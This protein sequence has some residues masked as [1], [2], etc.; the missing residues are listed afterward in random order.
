[1]GY[2]LG[3][4]RPVGVETV[5]MAPVINQTSE[6]AIELQ[7]TR[8]LRERIHLDGRLKQ[9]NT[10]DQADAVIEITLTNY[11]L[12]PITYR[13]EL[14][15][16]AQDYRLRIT[17]TARLKE[18]QTGKILSESTNYGEAVFRFESDLTNSKRNALPAAAQ[19]IAKLLIDDLIERW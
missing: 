2:Q 4:T 1:M 7:V 18:A 9:L 11:R 5:Y 17:A 8:A 6:P 13:N 19:E 14:K 12:S 15:T 3:G 16:A 10:R